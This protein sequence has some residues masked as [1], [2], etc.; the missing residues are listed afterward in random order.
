MDDMNTPPASASIAARCPACEEIF[1]L[2]AVSGRVLACPHCG[3]GHWTVPPPEKR[4]TGCAICGCTSFF[5]QRD[6]N[7]VLGLAVI[8]IAAVLVPKTYGL[9]MPVAFLVDWWLYRRTPELVRCYACRS[10]YRGVP[11]PESIKLYDHYTAETIEKS[12]SV[13]K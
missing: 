6:F 10:E 12:A 13:R 9:S 5:R 4:F 11:I 8:V 1:R 3:E 2:E 7:K